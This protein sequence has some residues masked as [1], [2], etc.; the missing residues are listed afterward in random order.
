[1]NIYSYVLLLE[2]DDFTL[3]YRSLIHFTLIF[4]YGVRKWSHF[5]LLPLAIPE[6]S[7]DILHNN[8]SI[9]LIK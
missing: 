9:L 3:I 2:F 4:V 5:I 8:N 7:V 6:S 1:M